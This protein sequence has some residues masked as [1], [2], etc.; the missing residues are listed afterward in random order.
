M[1]QVALEQAIVSLLD[2]L[3]RKGW[4]FTALGEALGVGRGVVSNW[5]NQGRPPDH[6]PMVL[7]ALEVLAQRP[8]PARNRPGPK[9]RRGRVAAGEL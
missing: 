5:I 9:G 8:A 1:A 2:E 7:M 4:T 3:L 6:A